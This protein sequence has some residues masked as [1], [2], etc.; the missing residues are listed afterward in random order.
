MIFPLVVVSRANRG[1]QN[2][3]LEAVPHPLAFPSLLCLMCR[4]IGEHKRPDGSLAQPACL[5]LPFHCHRVAGG[6]GTGGF[7][8]YKNSEDSCS[9]SH[10][11][12][13][14]VFSPS[15]LFCPFFFPALQV[16]PLKTLSCTFL[17]LGVSLE[18]KGNSL[19][20]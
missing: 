13:T 7:T 11:S 14:L 20:L 19:D 8:F 2:H 1:S 18:K 17:L 4:I 10:P 12:G 5:S 15:R 6:Y 9:A 3:C 16:F